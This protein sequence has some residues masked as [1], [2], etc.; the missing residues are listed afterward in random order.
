[1]KRTELRRKSA[2]RSRPKHIDRTD[3]AR[4]AW[5]TPMWGACSVCGKVGW[6][7]N[8]HVVQAQHI[9]EERPE[10]LYDR[11][12]AMRVGVDATCLCHA[13]H[14]NAFRRIPLALISAPAWEF[15]SE[16][17]GEGTA[18]QYFERRYAAEDR[19]AA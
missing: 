13:R 15:A 1:M 5:K 18:R 19:R 4:Q 7:V 10:L 12:N 8:H 9:P 3:P 16:L 11:R 17:M 14:T 6:L 2:L